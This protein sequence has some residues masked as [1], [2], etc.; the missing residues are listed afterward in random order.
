MFVSEELKSHL[1]TSSVVSGESLV[2]AEWNL[3]S[4]QNIK[5]IG[6]YRY[7]PNIVGD[8]YENIAQTFVPD[9]SQN[10]FFTGATD[11]DTLVDGGFENDNTPTAF[12][13]KKQKEKVLFSLEDCFG[14]M[15]PRSGINKLRWFEQKYSHFSNPEMSKRPRYY[16]ANKD[17]TF[18]YWSSFRTENGI[19]RGIANINSNET[20]FINDAAPFVVYHDPV[21]ANR[22]VVKMQT[23]VGDIDLGPFVQDGQN[24]GDPF[25]D[26]ANKTVPLTWKIQKLNQNSDWDSIIE[27]DSNSTRADGSDIVGPDGHVEL[28]YGLIVPE[29]L[30]EGFRLIAKYPNTSSLPAPSEVQDGS[31][32]QIIQNSTAL[33]TVYVAQNGEYVT[34]PATYGW[35]L[36]EDSR[37]Y[38]NLA[39][40]LTDPE[41]WIQT[42]NG[43]TFYREIDYLYGLRIVVETMNVFDSTFDL[44]EL[45][46]RLSA[47][48]S[49][50][51]TELSVTK[52]ASDLGN[53]GLP[54]GQLLASVGSLGIFDP[55][56]AFFQQNPKSIIK[57]YSSQN[58]KIRIY[59]VIK[60]VHNKDYYVPIKTMYSEGFPEINNKERKITLQLRDLFFYFESLT[61]PQI[62]LTDVSVSFAIAT[63]LDY[64]GFSNYAFYRNENESEEIIP[65]FFVKPDISV[66]EVLNEIARSTQSA[67]FFD[68]YNNFV[69]MSKNYFLPDSD[70]R[71]ASFVLKGS[72][73]FQKQGI[74]QNATTSNILANIKDIAFENRSVFNGGVVNYT[75]RSIQKSYGSIEEAM[76][77]DR[78]KFWV[79]KPALLWEVSPSATTKSINEESSN[80]TDYSLAAIPLSSTL[81]AEVP[82]VSNHRL[83]RNVM[84]F[85]DAIYWIGR[86]NG[87]FFAN[88]EMI[89]YDAVQYSIPG[90][91]QIEKND[92]NVIDDNVWITSVEDYQKYFAK[93]PFGGRM[94]PT[95]LVRIY[96]EPDYETVGGLTRMVNG[97]VSKHGRGQFG[98][99]IVSHPAGID[100]Y[101]TSSQNLYGVKMDSQY[102]FT[103]EIPR[104]KYTNLFLSPGSER[105]ALKVSEITLA[106]VGDFV[107]RT[108]NSEVN[109]I[110]SGTF[111]SSINTEDSEIVLS[112]PLVS[113]SEDEFVSQTEIKNP[114]SLTSNDP[115]AV[116]EF[117]DTSEVQVGQ[118]VSFSSED[119]FSLPS[120]TTVTA[121]TETSVT[122]SNA[123]ENAEDPTNFENSEFIFGQIVIPELRLFTKPPSTTEGKA[124]IDKVVTPNTSRSGVIKNIFSNRYKEEIK[125]PRQK[126]PAMT[127]ASAL[128]L[129]GN[130]SGTKDSPNSYLS[131][132]SKSLDAEAYKH[133][134]TRMRIIGKLEN[135]DSRGQSPEGSSIYYNVEKPS[136]GQSPSISG[137]SGGIAV[138]FNPETN[139]GYYFEIISLTEN[140]PQEYT[141][142][143]D[144]YN[145]LFYRVDR[146]SNASADDES[147]IPKR[148]FGGVA[149][150]NVDEGT[151]VG[152]SRMTVEENTSIYDLAVEYEDINNSRRFYLYIND[153]IVGIADDPDPLP[154]YNNIALFTRGNSKCMFENVYALSNNY[155]Q[156]ST[157]ALDTPANS[158]FGAEDI[159]AQQSLRKYS[160]SGIIQSTYLSGISSAEAP[161]YSMY[162][163]EF[164]TIMREASYFNIRY[165][166]AYPALYAKLSPTFGKVKS[167]TSSGFMASSYGAEFLIFNHTDST[168]SLDA[169]SGNY[170]RIQG[171]T[172][173]QEA[174][175]DLTVDEYFQ[176]KSDFS[177]PTFVA[178]TS[179][180]SP[181]DA[182]NV[183]TDIKLSRM[184]EGRKDFSLDAAYLQTQD[185][186][187]KMMDWIVRKVIRPRKS[188][189]V[190]VFPIP[191]LQ[192]GDIVTI[193]Y[194]SN[195]SF[196]ELAEKD[197]KFVVYSIDYQKRSSGPSMKLYLSEV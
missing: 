76:L 109:R 97:T 50:S 71:D 49:N 154:K 102:L 183:Y 112:S 7:R 31:A 140:D 107:E 164:G 121:V 120:F 33:G 75:T 94:Y 116:I 138:M 27:F 104:L 84:D 179:V 158:V 163:N 193:D 93:I 190:E 67:M 113:P 194:V 42:A 37:Q 41:P 12:V 43:E 82:F 114:T 143:S 160:M 74:A 159:N 55:E 10:L 137:S 15:R 11:A 169:D 46:P 144:I 40:K 186:A 155:S 22:V 83:V 178:P 180:A 184:S 6:N 63:L 170:L 162:Y 176:K 156:N 66:A 110:A 118:Y 64:V 32:Y 48:L 182:K 91:T 151:F 2:I 122:L 36:S 86:Y 61:A 128:V 17:D 98:T 53:T 142:G 135:N 95:G 80:Q 44:I 51:V 85:G 78:D 130:T 115:V 9:D 88:G 181:V 79:Y 150:I 161:R 148:L 39:T 18:K 141:S 119:D 171:V 192:L 19:E 45:S 87:Y 25:F 123:I 52:T 188:I 65:F 165:D 189:G 101:W 177:N 72:K 117:D 4:A 70:Q 100:E 16:I 139:N 1:E 38:S 56:Q 126:Y 166:K 20:Y 24:I 108:D 149:E 106:R 54:V 133:F 105:N 185:S 89:K 73:D 197:T 124:G 23:N 129:K 35:S 134:G 28:E 131:C 152:L 174:T 60:G 81:S 5:A 125:K 173:T 62:L 8:T 191:T 13:S 172:F 59:E 34:F 111:I 96:A 167:Y 195:N 136:T 187:N 168:L 175:H 99:K 3:N 26:P 90:L 68:E 30:R 77:L 21:A 69:V 58:V 92:P 145:V 14:K 153:Q 103:D 157:F 132:V 146:N 196:E 127:Q 29:N 57:N 47:D 147:A